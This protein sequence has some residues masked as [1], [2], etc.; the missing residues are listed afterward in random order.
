MV[1]FHCRVGAVVG[2]QLTACFSIQVEFS[3]MIYTENAGNAA[4]LRVPPRRPS[5]HWMRRWPPLMVASD[6]SRQVG[7][8]E[9]IPVKPSGKGSLYKWIMGSRFWFVN[10]V[11][12]PCGD[13]VDGNY[14]SCM[15][16]CYVCIVCVYIYINIYIFNALTCAD[17]G[18]ERCIRDMEDCGFKMFK[19]IFSFDW[20]L[21]QLKSATTNFHNISQQEDKGSEWL[22]I[23]ISDPISPTKPSDSQRGDD[24]LLTL[25]L[26][27]A[28]R[29]VSKRLGDSSTRAIFFGGRAKPGNLWCFCVWMRADGSFVMQGDYSIPDC[30]WF[31]V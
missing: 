28:E 10:Y 20:F 2:C 14:C 18:I 4:A 29:V 15:W 6:G 31:V 23:A 19:P 30:W 7:G 9:M 12:N 5:V 17:I 16:I 3:L 21:L 25:W 22:Q 27:E 24:K 11:K 8:G 26:E 13:H 1:I